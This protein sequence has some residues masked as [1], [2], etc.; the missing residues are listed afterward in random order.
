MAFDPGGELTGWDLTGFHEGHDTEAWR[1][2][3]AHE[4]TV[5]DSE[6]GQVSVLRSDGQSENLIP[7]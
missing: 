7:K 6:R 3:G 1:R 4:V 2:L 5:T